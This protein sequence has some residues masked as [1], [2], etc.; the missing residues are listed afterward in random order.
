MKTED[1][2]PKRTPLERAERRVLKALEIQTT[3]LRE[4][5]NT[6]HTEETQ[7]IVRGSL[8]ILARIKHLQGEENGNS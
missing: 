8:D 6:P 3:N 7:R 2:P 5:P 1:D 4:Y